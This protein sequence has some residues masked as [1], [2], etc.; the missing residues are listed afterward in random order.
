MAA[1]R[2]DGREQL[3]F[4][5]LDGKKYAYL[6]RRQHQERDFFEMMVKLQSRRPMSG[7]ELAECWKANFPDKDKST[8]ELAELM[9]KEQQRQAERMQ[10]KTAEDARSSPV[11]RAS[12]TSPV[13]VPSPAPSP[14]AVN[15]AAANRVVPPL[16]IKHSDPT[17]SPSLPTPAAR[18]GLLSAT[19]GSQ[20]RRVSGHS[21]TASGVSS[22]AGSAPGSARRRYNPSTGAERDALEDFIAQVLN[23]D[24]PFQTP[25]TSRAASDCGPQAPVMPTPRPLGQSDRYSAGLPSGEC[26]GDGTLRG[27][28]SSPRGATD[29]AA[30]RFKLEIEGQ[31]TLKVVTLPL[32]SQ[33]GIYNELLRV[34]ESKAP[35]QRM[36][37]FLDADGDSVEIEDDESLAMFLS[38]L[39]ERQQLGDRIVM[40]CGARGT[41][42]ADSQMSRI[43]AGTVRREGRTLATLAA[44]SAASN[45]VVSRRASSATSASGTPTTV[46]LAASTSPSA[47]PPPAP[48]GLQAP[49]SPGGVRPLAELRGHSKAVYSCAVDAT[50]GTAVSGGQDGDLIVW[51]VSE[52]RQLRSIQCTSAQEG[53]KPTYVL[54]C[55]ISADGKW[56]VASCAD[57]SV[58]VFNAHSGVRRCIL[59]GHSNRAYAV[60]FSPD[61]RTIASGSSDNTVKIWDG[62]EGSK[63]FTLRGHVSDVYCVAWSSDGHW[64]VSSGA[65]RKLRLWHISSIK[66]SDRFRH[67]FSGHNDCVWSACFS[68]DSTHLLSAAADREII[69]WHIRDRAAVWSVQSA[70][71]DAIHRA[72]FIESGK[73]ILTCSRDQRVML[74]SA[75]DGEKQ[76]EFKA[77]DKPVYGLCAALDRVV[78]C[79]HD[80]TVKLWSTSAILRERS[81][82]C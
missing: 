32:S 37:S 51:S 16:V 28:S 38:E 77:H 33:S 31:S 34:V 4:R 42:L 17:A 54:G 12:N 62:M 47:S 11:V 81:L 56:V 13:G 9:Q 1:G 2:K 8:E 69:L 67:A 23:A 36:L 43:T 68:P 65:D 40:Q 27:S 6:G 50:A 49:L 59:K 79:S 52:Q 61:A 76:I 72:I 75:R 35:G 21:R 26:S 58:R 73:T 46:P 66:E 53:A 29:S 15:L 60:Q 41:A 78:S 30:V 14:T 44:S 80:G 22:G 70:H 10:R 82:S 3:F 7:S 57:K 20:S 18:D 5:M 71:T 19:Y 74:W 55:D 45:S 39:E 63:R 64:L 48:A 24:L 25:A